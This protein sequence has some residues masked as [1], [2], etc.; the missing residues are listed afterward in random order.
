MLHAVNLNKTKFYK[1]YL[2]EKDEPENVKAEDEIASIILGPLSFLPACDN[3]LF[4]G[5]V[6]AANGKE[7]FLTTEPVSNV[8]YHF[9]PRRQGQ[10]GSI[11]PDLFVQFQ[12]PD[13][14]EKYLLVELKW[15][16]KLSGSDQLHKQWQYF[17]TDTEKTNALH[18]FIGHDVSEAAAAPKDDESGGDVWQPEDK[19]VLFS[20]LQLR[21]YL[22]KFLHSDSHL[23][24]WAFLADSFLD[25]VGVQKFNGFEHIDIQCSL[26]EILPD[27]IFWSV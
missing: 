12:W 3:Q 6:L 25:R 17:L 26:P 11:E 10:I 15:N 23:N 4:W 14:T 27:R 22:K 2:G 9:W 21:T 1:R 20:W 18:I 24:R 16:A 5:Q 19:L 13:K 7:E 8:Q